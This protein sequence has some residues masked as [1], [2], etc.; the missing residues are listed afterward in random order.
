MRSRIL[1]TLDF[2]NGQYI[3][4]RQKP[5]L[6]LRIF[7]SL[8]A[9]ARFVSIVFRT[10]S[11]AKR[12]GIDHTDIVKSSIKV[13]RTMERIGVRFQISGLEYLKDIEGPCIFISN[14]MSTLE[15]VTMAAF[16]PHRR[17]T[18]V[19]K[20]SLVKYP[21]F[22]HILLA[23]KP[24]IVSRNNPR[25]D[26]RQMIE[27]GSALLQ[28]GISIIVFPQTTR[29]LKFDASRFNTI[30]IK[31]ARRANVPVIP[32][33]LKTDVWGN[34]K[35]IKEFGPV[36]PN[37][38][39]FFRFGPPLRIHGTGSREHQKVIEFIKTNLNSWEE[40]TSALPS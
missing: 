12:S 8:Y 19:I 2:D 14:H 3:S 11:K 18:F 15:T 1:D 6:L 10:S 32:V 22:R 25:E 23:M 5:G 28:E 17:A 35:L 38:D 33:A 29:T 7:P 20:E 4:P 9:Y 37:K 30:G 31:L 27:R 26:F 39:V 13:I 34:G 16:F 24:I 40:M 36:N 21:I